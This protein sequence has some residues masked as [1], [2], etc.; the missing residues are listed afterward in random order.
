MAVCPPLLLVQLFP[1][2]FLPW[3]WILFL[4]FFT[5]LEFNSD[6]SLI[7][8]IFFHS[9][10][11]WLKWA[12]PSRTFL[13]TCFVVFFWIAVGV[14]TIK[15]TCK[16]ADSVGRLANFRGNHDWKIGSNSCLLLSCMKYSPCV[17]VR[18]IASNCISIHGMVCNR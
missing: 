9:G 17:S 8:I 13:P 5:C 10:E 7:S 2:L 4:P 1:L 3:I 6:S 15:S 18:N 16:A 12:A 14:H 11:R